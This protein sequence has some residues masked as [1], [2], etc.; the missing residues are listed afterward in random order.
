MCPLQSL[1]QLSV[2]EKLEKKI[3]NLESQLHEARQ[4]MR[5]FEGYRQKYLD[6][7]TAV[8][9]CYERAL[10]SAELLDAKDPR[11]ALASEQAV[12]DVGRPLQMLEHL[13]LLF[14]N[15]NPTQ[16]SL[17]VH[18]LTGVIN[19]MWTDMAGEA[20]LHRDETNEDIGEG[21]ITSK[22]DG[23][24]NQNDS[25]DKMSQAVVAPSP[26][27]PSTHLFKP[28]KILKIVGDR[29]R[30]ARIREHNVLSKL[31]NVNMQLEE[32][33]RK[34]LKEDKKNIKIERE[35][36]RLKMLLRKGSGSK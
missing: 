36:E 25:K 33:H 15:S 19:R 11:I 21:K 35:L 13:G 32:A 14:E 3:S 24:D 2:R 34:Y 5:S 8:R 12:A 29:L 9:A 16:A 28:D 31:N 4:D 22:H 20:A 17:K 26:G 27:D 6:T 23:S 1:L 10:R 30:N 18:M 7:T